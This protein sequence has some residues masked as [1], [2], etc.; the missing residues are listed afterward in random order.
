[1][2][3][4][5]LPAMRCLMMSSS[6]MSAP[7]MTTGQQLYHNPPKLSH[8][9]PS[10]YRFTTRMRLRIMK[11]P[12]GLSAIATGRRLAALSVGTGLQGHCSGD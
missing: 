11:R 5:L 2:A 8:Q 12:A 6:V 9:S 7:M 1:M 10:G 4:T 3:R